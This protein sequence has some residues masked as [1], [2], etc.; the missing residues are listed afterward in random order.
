MAVACTG[1]GSGWWKDAASVKIVFPCWMH[2]TRRVV[3]DRPSRTLS[4]V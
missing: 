2:D 4:T 3:N 1:P